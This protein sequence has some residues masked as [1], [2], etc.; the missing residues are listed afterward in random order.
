MQI[1]E[2]PSAVQPL[3]HAATF[4]REGFVTL[5]PA[6]AGVIL[7]E[8]AYD[9]QRKV[10][11]DHVAVL[12]EQMRRKSWLKRGGIDFARLNGRLILA[13]GYHRL[14]SQIEAA[15]NI[16]WTVVIHEC[17]AA[18]EVRD[19][20]H[21]F[22]TNV[23]KRTNI[24]VLNGIG[25]ADEVGISKTAA[26]A[27]FGAA[28]IIATGLRSPHGNDKT[29]LFAQRLADDRLRTSQGLPP[30]AHTPERC[31]VDHPQAAERTAGSCR[32][33]AETTVRLQ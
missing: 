24:M 15:V 4:L 26:S 17:R 12:A 22:D 10:D 20:Y 2:A 13:N 7:R 14:T 21:K 28:P 16:E 3:Q 30:Q 25:F 5:N 32:F 18:D 23:R 1:T 9:G 33:H 8:C 31:G 6:Q 29:R 27:L 19:L 11:K